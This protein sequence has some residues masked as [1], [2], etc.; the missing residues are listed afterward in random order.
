MKNE[1]PFSTTK[2]INRNINYRQIVFFGA[3]NIAEKTNRIF[4]NSNKAF[5]V[6][7]SSNL[8]GDKQF[9]LKVK[10]PKNVNNNNKKYFIIICTTSFSEV[11]EQLSKYGYKQ[12]LDFAV[13]PI[14]NDLRSIDDLEK[15]EKKLIFTSGSP[16]KKDDKSGGGVYLLELKGDTWKYS[17][18]ISGNCYGLIKFG[19]NYISVDSDIGIFEFDKNF[20]ILRSKKLP[21]HSRGH[22]IHFNNFRSEFYVVCSYLDAILV[23]DKKFKVK[24]KIQISKKINYEKAPHHHCNDCVSYKNSC[25][26][27]MFSKSGNWKLDSFDGAIMEI[28]LIQKKTV[29][30]LTENLWMPHNPKIINGAFYVLDSLKG[31]LKGN[32]FNTI[33][34]FPAFTRGLAHD[35]SFFYVGQSR[36]R[37]FSKN[38][39][40]NNNTSIDAGIT[41]FDEEKKISRFLQVSSKISEIHS[42]EIYE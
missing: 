4:S 37:N 10:N 14:L 24:N 29:S 12:T 39:G 33:G 17:K 16:K 13:S 30:T 27:S 31:D 7:N 6:D 1:I 35:G 3:G 38:I 5:I 40:I 15:L 42:I 32:N 2:E 28:D 11:S 8:W 18:K 26:V 19:K 34:S 23:L 22:G 36:N 25:Y 20:K 21:K 41:I 9:N